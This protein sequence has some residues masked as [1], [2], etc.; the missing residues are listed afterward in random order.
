MKFCFHENFLVLFCSMAPTQVL[1]HAVLL[2]GLKIVRVIVEG[3]QTMI[4][5]LSKVVALKWRKLPACPG[6]IDRII[7][8]D[9]VTEPPYSVHDWHSAVSHSVKLIE[10]AGLKA[11]RHKEQICC[12]RDAVRHVDGEAHPAADVIAVFGFYAPKVLLQVFPP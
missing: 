8:V 7:L 3:V 9:R 10:P 4:N 2:D 12:C 5:G 1:L 11:G 6:M